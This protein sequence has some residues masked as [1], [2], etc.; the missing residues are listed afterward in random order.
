MTMCHD[1]PAVGDSSF[2]HRLSPPCGSVRVAAGA[3]WRAPHGESHGVE[4]ESS[5]FY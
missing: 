1:S 4:I 5:T 3:W 2:R